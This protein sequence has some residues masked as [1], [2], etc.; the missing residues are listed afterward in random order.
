MF[1]K[2]MAMDHKGHYTATLLIVIAMFVKVTFDFNYLANFLAIISVFS[3]ITQ[4]LIDDKRIFYITFFPMYVFVG[5][6][7]SL[8]IVESGWDMVELGGIKTFPSFSL[9]L[10]A[11]T[12]V[13]F[14]LVIFASSK[15]FIYKIIDVGL[16]EKISSNRL[17][18]YMPVLY[19]IVI[20]IPVVIYGSA[21]SVTNGNRVVYY[22]MIPSLFN[23][24]FQIKLF[25]LPL[26]GLYFFKNKKFFWMFVIGIFVWNI[27]VGEKATGLW[28]SL[29]AIFLPYFFIKH[30]DISTKKIILIFTLSA[31]LVV[32]IIIINYVFVEGSGAFFIFDRI[33]MQ[34]QLWWYFFDQH[35]TNNVPIHNISEEFRNEYN[36]LI[37]LMQNAMPVSLFNSYMNRGVVLTSGFPSIFLFYFGYFW[38]VPTLFFALLFGIPV[39]LVSKSLYCGNVFCLIVSCKLLFS[40]NVLFARGDVES[41]FD[42]KLFIYFVLALILNYVPRLKI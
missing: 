27:L 11:L 32:G 19:L 10:L 17:V 36:G 1:T 2:A 26:A 42:I 22:Q 35:I 6:L 9:L 24:L 29:Y 4:V 18:F 39:Y 33:S 25:I 21:L 8:F 3:S 37:V 40:F 15:L 41:F 20:Y 28:Q 13:L 38:L 12:A 14:N 5:Q 7:L 30:N 23:Y 31:T 34:G 16:I